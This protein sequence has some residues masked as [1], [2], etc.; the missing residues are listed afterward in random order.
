M[1]TEH[2]TKHN[3][4]EPHSTADERPSSR[5]K[6]WYCFKCGEDG[7]LDSPFIAGQMRAKHNNST[8]PDTEHKPKKRFLAQNPLL[9]K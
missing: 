6:P 1:N 3:E 5:P 9:C 8:T 2:P 4:A 7:Q